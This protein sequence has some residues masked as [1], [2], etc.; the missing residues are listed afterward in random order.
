MI[1]SDRVQKSFTTRSTITGATGITD[2]APQND[3]CS[4]VRTYPVNAVATVRN[5]IIT[6]TDHVC[7]QCCMIR[8]INGMQIIP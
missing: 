1:H 6:P 4:Y 7:V 2:L 8:S 5:K 3:I